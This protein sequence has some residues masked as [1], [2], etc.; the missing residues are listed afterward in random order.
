MI[1]TTLAA[2]LLLQALAAGARPQEPV[3]P[4][5]QAAPEDAPAAV[6]ETLASVVGVRDLEWKPYRAML[7]GLDAFKLFHKLAPDA[8]ARFQLRPQTADASL[9]G[10]RLELR[11]GDAATF[12]PVMPDATF[13]LPRGTA[14]EYAEAELALSRNR[15]AYRW[16]PSVRS[17]DVPRHARRL[18]DLRLE[19]EMLWAI[20]KDE[21]SGIVRNTARLVGDPC[22]SALVPLRFP[23]PGK[24]A[25]ATLVSGG[26]TI[27]VPVSADG[28][29]YQPPLHDTSWPDDALVRFDLVPQG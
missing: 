17:P 8:E 25:G 10:L 20:Q 21:L 23:A 12:L 4:P 18:G 22:A 11:H 19:C 5:L 6:S 29:S 27:A 15:D 7:K 14:P 28:A 2:V 26:R 16:R 1:K 13:S 24:L 9:D 3:L